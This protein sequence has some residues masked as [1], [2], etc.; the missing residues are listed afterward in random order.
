MPRCRSPRGK[1]SGKEGQGF[2]A[3]GV[4]WFIPAENGV[5]TLGE[6]VVFD[7]ENVDDFDF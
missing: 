2:W 7:A 6:P 5:V 1:I 4:G 3:V